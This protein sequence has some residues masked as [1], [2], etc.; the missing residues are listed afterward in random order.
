MI[1]VRKASARG[2]A[3]HGW[4]QSFHTFSFGSYHD[5]EHMNFRSLRVINEDRIA[6]GQ[7][8]GTHAHA[9]DPHRCFDLFAKT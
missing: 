5:R 7:G 4:L 8:F 9:V 3:D 6:A 2:Y 1:A